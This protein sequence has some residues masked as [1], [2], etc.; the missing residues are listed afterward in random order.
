MITDIEKAFHNLANSF[1]ELREQENRNDYINRFYEGN[2][3]KA[4]ESLIDS[5]Y[6]GE[7]VLHNMYDELIELARSVCE[8]ELS[9]DTAA[10]D[11]IR[12]FKT[13]EEYIEAAEKHVAD[14]RK[15][16][17]ETYERLGQCKK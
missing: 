6:F 10:G 9:V 16:V 1:N 15:E 2:I 13:R 11:F 5:D 17:N 12:T 7:F 3:D 14:I 8:A 4:V